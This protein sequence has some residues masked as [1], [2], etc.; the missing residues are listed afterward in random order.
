MLSEIATHSQFD[1]FARAEKIGG[2][3]GDLF[4]DPAGLEGG[5]R[6]LV[7]ALRRIATGRDGCAVTPRE[8]A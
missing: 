4:N 6:L 1:H 8:F 2:I 5:E 3:M 7:E